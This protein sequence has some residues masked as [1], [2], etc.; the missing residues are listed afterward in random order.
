[1][2]T[3]RVNRNIPSVPFD[4]PELLEQSQQVEITGASTPTGELAGDSAVG[5][6]AGVPLLLAPLPMFCL[7]FVALLYVSAIA[8]ACPFIMLFFARRRIL[9]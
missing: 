2:T 1:V 6:L 8:A 7:G 5:E 4:P 3:D 9:I